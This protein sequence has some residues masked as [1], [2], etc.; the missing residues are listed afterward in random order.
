MPFRVKIINEEGGGSEEFEDSRFR[1]STEGGIQQF[2]KK[3]SLRNR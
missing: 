1:G 3:L 2:Q